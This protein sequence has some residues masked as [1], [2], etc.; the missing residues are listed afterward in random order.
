[1]FN[2]VVFVFW[3]QIFACCVGVVWCFRF[4]LGLWVVWCWFRLLVVF[5]ICSLCL[6]V[7]VVFVIL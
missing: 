3:V 7:C 2:V 6:V 4:S 1:M 5:G